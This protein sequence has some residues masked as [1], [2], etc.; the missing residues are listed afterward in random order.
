MY[1]SSGQLALLIRLL[2]L[3]TVITSLA[4][5]DDAPASD[6]SQ[7]GT[8]VNWHVSERLPAKRLGVAWQVT[9]GEG[10]SQI[11]GGGD[12]IYVATGRVAAPDNA[13]D[14]VPQQIT[15]V[16][17]RDASTGRV[18]WEHTHATATIAAQQTFSGDPPSPQATPALLNDRLFVISFTGQLQCL[19]CDDG[20]VL[21]QQHLVDDLHADPVQFGFASSPVV[22]PVNTRQIFVLAAGEQGGF[23]ALNAAT[24]AIEWTA[25]CPSFSYATP[26]LAS[27]QGQPQWILVSQEDVRSVAAGTGRPLWSYPLPEAGL[28]NVPTPVVMNDTCIVVSGQ[29]CQGTRGLTIR[30]SADQWEVTERWSLKSPLFFYTNQLR[31]SENL[32]LGADSRTLVAINTDTGERVGRWRGF[33]DANLIRCQDQLI[34]VDGRGQLTRLQLRTDHG[35]VTG[36]QPVDKAEAISGRCWTA[37]SLIGQR[38]FIRAGKQ[39]VCLS[40]NSDNKL[41]LLTTVTE[42]LELAMNSA[43]EDPVEQ[44]F[45]IFEEQ[46]AAAALTR[47][48]ELRQQGQLDPAAR[49]ALA[50]AAHEQGL[51]AITELIAR[52]AKLDYPRQRA[53]QQ[54]EELLQKP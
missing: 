23:H 46:G 7:F 32:L 19:S 26:V 17:R 16:T 40:G 43:V 6:W 45:T 2:C 24:G 41:P 50:R 12:A 3:T 35:R 15:T 44:I 11:V 34:C 39:L 13:A 42:P 54:I 47:Y 31:L 4:R 10:R 25:P 38:L 48:S 8:A 36:L 1:F 37:A 18:V 21:W 51:T 27:L 5:A 9:S 53:S 22:Q 20:R 49:Y 52:D 33:G 30:R 29:G 14:S 28:T